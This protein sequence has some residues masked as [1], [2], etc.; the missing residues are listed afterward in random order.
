M[1]DFCMFRTRWK[2][3]GD[4]ITCRRNYSANELLN[5]LK[6]LDSRPRK[7]RRKIQ[8]RI[9]LKQIT[10]IVSKFSEEQRTAVKAIG[11]GGILN[12]SC[13]KLNHGICEW[14]V[15]NF[16]PD[17]HSLT[18]HGRKFYIT[19]SHVEKCLGINGQCNIVSMDSVEGFREMYTD[20]GVTK[21]FVEIKGLLVYLLKSTVANE[22]FKRKFAL[23]ILGSFLCP[24]TK[25]AVHESLIH[26]V[27][28]IRAMENVNWARITLE[29]LCN[30]IRGQRTHSRVHAN[31]CLFFLLVFYLERVSPTGFH[32]IPRTDRPLLFWSDRQIK[33]V[34]RR[35]KKIGGYMRQGVGVIFTMEE[36]S[37]DGGKDKTNGKA[38]SSHQIPNVVLHD[39]K[40]TLDKVVDLLER[41][42]TVFERY[43]GDQVANNQYRVANKKQASND[44][45][46]VQ[47]NRNSR[48]PYK[49]ERMS[50]P[51]TFRTHEGVVD[52]MK[53]QG[54]GTK[55]NKYGPIFLQNEYD[56]FH[57]TPQGTPQGKTRTPKGNSK[58]GVDDVPFSPSLSPLSGFKPMVALSRGRKRKITNPTL[59]RSLRLSNYEPPDLRPR[60]ELKKGP[61]L[62][63]PYT[64]DGR[65]KRKPDNKSGRAQ[66]PIAVDDVKFNVNS[67]YV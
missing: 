13:T 60:A 12:L 55:V 23:Y 26:L 39:M 9:A 59:R 50:T 62:S 64:R 25:P 22:E 11:L 30:A 3:G 43:F 56:G 51:R 10:E 66:S 6:A 49:G 17:T 54:D 29:F 35:F 48:S 31:G 38:S 15:N 37:M 58:N 57:T 7:R 42:T 33:D 47:L 2:L 8:T 27:S 36:E 52:P 53:G 20:L 61:L 46:S 14:L 41:Q 65:N 40:S 63:S 67:P 18:V 21:G 5:S 19:K 24:T 16:D 4:G 28:D 44:K 45:H 34:L 32:Q 1:L